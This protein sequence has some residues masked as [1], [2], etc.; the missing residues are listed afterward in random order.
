MS[1]FQENLK[2][3]RS[4]IDDVDDKFLEILARRV[5]ISIAIAR[6]KRVHDL[7]ILDTTRESQMIAERVSAGTPLNLPDDWISELFKIILEGCRTISCQRLDRE[8]PLL[9]DCPKRQLIIGTN[10]SPNSR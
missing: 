2:S 7:P 8:Y 10:P 6:L 3:L 4:Q 9:A 5:E 1:T